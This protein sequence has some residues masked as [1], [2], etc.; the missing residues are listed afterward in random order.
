MDELDDKVELGNDEDSNVIDDAAKD[1]TVPIVQY[2]VSSYGADYDV[3]GL[4]KRLERGDIKVPTFQRGFVWKLKEASRFIESLLLGLPVPSV[5]FAR[6]TD[7]NKLLVID[8]QQR[9]KTLQF[10]YGGYF[11]PKPEDKKQQVFRLSE[12]Q[13]EFNNVTYSSL[14]EPDKRRLNDSIIHAIIIKQESPENDNTSVYHIFDRLNSGGQRLTPQEIRAAV[15]H[16]AFIDM[17]RNLNENRC[18]RTIYG[19]KNSRLKDQEFILRFLAFYY[20]SEQ[21]ER[22][23]NEFLNKFSNRYRKADEA[24][25]RECEELFSITIDTIEKCLGN[26]AFRPEGSLN[27][28]V[29]DSVMVGLAKQLQSSKEIN[30]DRVKEVYEKLVE[31]KDYSRAVSQATAVEGNVKLRM[32]KAIEAFARV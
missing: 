15:D 27:A 21:Y 13:S 19:K 24:F 3:E 9:L 16:G 32:N 18:W 14:E 17:I 20:S 26:S 25:L 10:F 12:V 28:A 5:F 30:L 11:N 7:T 4:V 2:Q 1:A 23:M 22:P 29:F 31:D 8:G 6:E